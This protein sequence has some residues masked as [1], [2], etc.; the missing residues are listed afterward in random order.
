MEMSK[1]E[2]KK[3]VIKELVWEN[4]DSP[5][6]PNNNKSGNTMKNYIQKKL[7]GV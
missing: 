2:K 6:Q 7:T 1:L 5:I 4:L 3:K